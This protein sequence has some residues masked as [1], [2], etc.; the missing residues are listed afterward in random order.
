[1][2][3]SAKDASSSSTAP[4]LLKRRGRPPGAG[5]FHTC[6]VC[7]GCIIPSLICVVIVLKEGL[8]LLAGDPGA[9]DLKSAILLLML[10]TIIGSTFSVAFDPARLEAAERAR[11]VALQKAEPSV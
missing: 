10:L 9:G 7:I 2:I 4:P 8:E 6:F 5:L 11:K 3:S 1:M